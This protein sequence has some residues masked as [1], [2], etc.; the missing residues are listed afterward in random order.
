MTSSDVFQV[1]CEHRNFD[2]HLHS[3]IQLKEGTCEQEELT[4]TLNYCLSSCCVHNTGKLRNMFELS[5]VGTPVDGFGREFGNAAKK[6]KIVQVPET[7]AL[8]KNPED[9]FRN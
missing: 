9:F 8:R 5:V 2:E 3:K 7:L 4:S 1:Q 6:D